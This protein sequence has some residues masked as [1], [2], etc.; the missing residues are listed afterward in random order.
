MR[1][2]IVVLVIVVGYLQYV[3]W[4]GKGGIRDVNQLRATVVEQQLKIA[5]LNERNQAL[6][7]EVLDLK[8]GMEAIEELARSEMGM[9]KEDEIFIQIIDPAS[10]IERETHADER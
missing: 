9:I 5:A 10:G 1:A 8:H 3:L 7:A 2:A 4:L 6:A